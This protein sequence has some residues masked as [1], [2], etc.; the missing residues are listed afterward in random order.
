MKKV[1]FLWIVAFAL[2]V[3]ESNAAAQTCTPTPLFVSDFYHDVILIYASNSTGDAT[4]VATIGGGKTGLSHPSFMALDSAGNLYVAINNAKSIEVFAPGS[5]GNVPPSRVIAGKNT[6][7]E[8][9]FGV[10]VSSANIY[11]TDPSL[12]SIFLFPIGSEGNVTPSANDRGQQHGT[13]WP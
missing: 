3:V 1:S 4:P 7:F 6:G 8:I 10:A 5:S 12:N 13:E 2:I 11:V 9:P